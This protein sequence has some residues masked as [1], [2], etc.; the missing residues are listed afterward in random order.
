MRRISAGDIVE[1]H[2]E[3]VNKHEGVGGQRATQQ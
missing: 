1:W 3:A 2:I